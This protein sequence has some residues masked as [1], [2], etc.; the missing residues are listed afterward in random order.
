VIRVVDPVRDGRLP[1]PL[2]P[3]LLFFVLVTLAATNR[4][5][6]EEERRRWLEAV[7]GRGGWQLGVKLQGQQ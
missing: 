1:V 7:G 6:D 3:P 5:D 4:R 2:L